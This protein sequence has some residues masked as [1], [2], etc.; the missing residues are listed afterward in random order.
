[1]AGGNYQLVMIDLDM[2]IAFIRDL[3]KGDKNRALSKKEILAGVERSDIAAA[4]PF[5][6]QLA[7][8]VDY[9]EE[10]LTGEMED[11]AKRSGAGGAVFGRV[12]RKAG[13]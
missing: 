7:G 1:M 8:G 4:L 10:L 13:S 2:I 3:F 12:G 9:T 5:F 6:K 11:I